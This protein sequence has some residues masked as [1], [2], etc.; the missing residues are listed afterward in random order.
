MRDELA[1]PYFDLGA[2]LALRATFARL[3]PTAA[4]RAVVLV[5]AGSA[6]PAPQFWGEKDADAANSS[7]GVYRA[8]SSA[9]LIGNDAP[10]P[11]I[12]P[13]TTSD[14]TPSQKS[15]ASSYFVLRTSYLTPDSQSP[16]R[17]SLAILAGSFDPLT[18]AHLALAR[19]AREVGGCA[20]VYLALSRQTVDKEA[21]V[22]P[23]DT[24]RA[25]LLRQVA[26]R[27][28]GLG[29]V[30]F[31]RGLY[32][33]QAV[34]AR[35]AF[36]EADIR[37]IVGFDKARQIFDRRYYA[38]RDAALR[39]LFGNVSLLVAPRADAG[40]EALADL[41][42]RPENAPFRGRVGALPFD[43]AWAADSATTVR[44]AAR[45]GASFAALVPPET[46]AFV[47]A[48]APYATADTADMPDYYARREALIAR[49]AAGETIADGVDPWA[50][51]A[52]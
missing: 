46:V 45:A 21:R 38:D 51:L 2:I 6:P 15:D 34:A 26:A 8:S 5:E 10:L 37:F 3:D 40:P 47:A 22:R 36:P 50:A 13:L 49:L 11:S 42:A 29:V 18:N 31:N 20:A 23:T 35:A 19:A 33:E 48:L 7:G 27:E 24:D 41:L 52:H 1:A 4:A 30:L 17:R 16:R 28:P 44:E 9:S 39:Q 12:S 14:P 25:L 43:P 32:A